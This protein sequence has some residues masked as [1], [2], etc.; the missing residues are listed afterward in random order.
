MN[1]L[2]KFVLFGKLFLVKFGLNKKG[3]G[4]PVKPLSV[5]TS[6]SP[7]TSLLQKSRICTLTFSNFAKGLSLITLNFF[8]KNILLGSIS[9]T[10]YE[11]FMH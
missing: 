11:Q 5:I 8:G 10:F 9:P 6:V 1:L 4:N 2:W 7:H 3:C